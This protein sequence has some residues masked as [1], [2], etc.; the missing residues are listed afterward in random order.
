MLRSIFRATLFFAA[1]AA[2]GCGDDEPE[3]LVLEPPPPG[4]GFQIATNDTVVPAGHEYQ[5]CYFYKISDLAAS[6]GLDPTQPVNL[7]RI[8]IAQ[9]QGSHHYNIFRV[10]T[11][12]GLDPANGAFQHAEDGQGEC[13][14]SPNWADW[15]LIA[16]NQNDLGQLDW[17]FPD[18][19]ANILQP[20][21]WIMAQI[22]YVNAS[23]QVTPEAG[24][25]YANFWTMPADQVQHE[26]GTLFATKQSI[27]ICQSNPTPSFDA[28]CNINATEPVHIIGA[29]GHFHSRGTQFD[30]FTWDGE[31]MLRPDDSDRFYQSLSWDHPPMAHSPELDV[32]IADGGGVWYTCGYEWTPPPVGCEALNTRDQ[33]VYMTPEDQLD[34]CY[35]FGGVVESSEHCNIFVYYYPKVDDIA[36]F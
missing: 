3:P 2:A 35:T 18:G 22:H 25:V 20:D 24:K 6:N 34:C 26:M 4:E 13:F 15:P 21:E 30:I 16:N 36:C 7:H 5:D 9:K 33:T 8:Q 12:V 27:R 23:T 1:I 17:T 14:K 32:E 28:G 31:S 10:R 11:I 19:V 29:N